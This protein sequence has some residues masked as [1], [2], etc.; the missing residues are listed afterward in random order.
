MKRRT[1]IYLRYCLLINLAILQFGSKVFAQ[2]NNSQVKKV[3]ILAPLYLDSAFDDNGYKLGSTNIPKMYL[4]GLDFYNGVMMAV[5]SLQKDGIEMEVWVFDTKK[6]GT[7]PL[8]LSQEVEAVHSELI[9]ASF[10]NSVEQKVFAEFAFNHNIPLVS[11][12]YPNDNYISAN[13]FFL[14]INSSL[15]T[16]VEAMY[17]YL[18]RAYPVAKYL[19][20]NRKGILEDK[21]QTMFSEMGKKTYPINYKSVLMPDDFTAAQ[22]LPLLDS[23]KQNVIICGSLDEKF[24]S[25]LLKNLE[26]ATSYPCTLM[27]MPTWDGLKPAFRNGNDKLEIIYSTPYQFNKADMAIVNI[28]D[29]YKSTFFARPSDMVFK[30]FENMYHFSKL[31]VKY[32]GDILNNLSDISFRISNNYRFEPVKLSI[33]SQVPDYIENKKLYFI[34]V[35]NG[36]VKSVNGL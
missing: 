34:H 35:A 31:L 15:K 30:G 29:K 3:V 1:Y 9:I 19:Y 7:T 6:N 33:T 14:M 36:M 11:A 24:G 18:Q 23:T 26:S 27:G 17:K 4:P 12:T 32:N 22:L 2:D 16:H 28:T 13:P 20:V 25:L 5:D 10:T 8:Q 21:I